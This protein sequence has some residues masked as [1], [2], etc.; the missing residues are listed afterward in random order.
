MLISV[1]SPVY[2]CT[3][4]LERIVDRVCE[5]FAGTGIEWEIVFVDDRGPGEPWPLIEALAERDDRVRGVRLMRNHGQHLAI[6]AGFAHARGDWI[7]VIDCD[8]QDDPHVLPEL[9]ERAVAEAVDAVIVDR[10]AWRDSYWRRAASRGFF[11]ALAW[12]TGFRIDG[13]AGNFG[14]YS[15]RMIDT[16]LT[17]KDKEVFLPAMTVMTGLPRSSYVVPRSARFEG[18]SSY[19]L[20]RLVRL[21]AALVV[22]FSDRPLKLSVILGLVMSSL[23][24]L[25]GILVFI[26]WL[27]GRIEV[28]GWASI[29]LSVWFIGGL[30]LS[31][32]G[33]QGFYI[34]RIFTEVQ[35]RPRIRVLETTEEAAV[36]ADDL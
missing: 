29:I 23:S 5:A 35:R 7:A 8:L 17:F 24:L 30:V 1:V 19:N 34:G 10:G 21:A 27:A 20:K 6:W 36:P 3:S 12:V 33:V 25:S 9:H 26:A 11:K 22:R 16:L 15:R 13:N 18:N 14:I 31:V 2:N 32:L 28:E 4:C